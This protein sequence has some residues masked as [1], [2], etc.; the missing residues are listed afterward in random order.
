[1][2]ATGPGSAP[3]WLAMAKRNPQYGKTVEA[4]IANLPPAQVIHYVNCRRVVKGP[5]KI[6]E[7]QRFFAWF[8]K[9]KKNSGGASYGGFIEDLKREALATAT[10]EEREAIAKFGSSAAPVAPVERPVAK[11]PGH[12]WTV[13]EVA[14]LAE[15]GL[16]G[17]DKANGKRM[18]QAAMCSACHRF[19]G[20]GG[21]AGP[22][23]SALGGR[24][25]ARDIADSILDPS[26][27]ISDQYAFELITK[28]AGSQ[29]TGKMLDEKDDHWIVAINPFDFGQT[30]EIERNQIKERK[31]SPVSPMP[32]A[33]INS[34]NPDELKDLLAYLMGK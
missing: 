9:L 22:D 12:A 32:P 25:S 4:M 28:T 5:W 15:S 7:R 3:D 2:D 30:V 27:V 31:P 13:D 34:L 14:A 10:P 26:K 8:D 23:L 24:F 18:F 11:G 1:M 33:L 17:R 20:E 6:E 16:D 29:V 19:A 21:A